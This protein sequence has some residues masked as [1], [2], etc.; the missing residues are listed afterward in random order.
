MK[1]IVKTKYRGVKQEFYS[2]KQIDKTEALYRIVFG[3]RTNGKTFAVLYK[4]LLDFVEN[5]KMLCY[6]R[7]WQEDIKPKSAGTLFDNFVNNEILGNIIEKLT[8]GKYNSYKYYLR[9][10]TLVYRNEE[11]V[12]ESEDTEPFCRSFAISDWE[13]DKSTPHP[14]AHYICFDEFLTRGHYLADE[15]TKFNNLLSTIIRNR[16]DLIIYMVANTVNFDC[17][18]FTEMGL[19]HVRRMKQ[20]DIDIYK[21]TEEL[22]V[23]V[24]Y[25]KDT[26]EGK[27]SNKYFAFDNPALQMITKGSW[28]TEVYPHLQEVDKYNKD[29]VIFMWFIKYLDSIV[30]VNLIDKGDRAYIY[31][32]Y[33]TSDIKS[34]KDILYEFNTVSNPYRYSNMTRP[35]D[36]LSSK[37]WQLWNT[38]PKFYQTNELGE[39]IRN[40]LIKCRE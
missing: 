26:S 6:I 15:Y 24:E 34:D 19:K 11:G 31:M 30:Q 33:K 10:Y 12:I 8:D 21:F 25:C 4:G 5:R 1:Q 20:G 35:T 40:Y 38:Y 16:G 28:Q 27:A 23:A 39:L 37:V 18:Y 36:K 14:R 32:H 3:E 2:L 29:E 17:P 22:K 7:R 9:N 13:H